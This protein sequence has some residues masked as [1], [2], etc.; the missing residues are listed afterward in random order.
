MM[1]LIFTESYEKRARKFL[2]KHPEL[3]GQYT[4]TLKLL[5]INPTHKAL[6]LHKL[7]G[8]LKSLHSASI[9]YSYRI[10]FKFIIKN[11][12]IIL[13]DVGSHDEVY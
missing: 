10:A 3:E 1:T 5:E 4:K 2:K 8:R 9:N 6:R 7:K 12:E 13:V 11:E